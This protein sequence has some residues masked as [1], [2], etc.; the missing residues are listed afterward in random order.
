MVAD[1]APDRQ[2]EKH[3]YDAA[4]N[5]TIDTTRRGLAIGMTYDAPQPPLRTRT[6]P[7][8]AY[9]KRDDG[10][11]TLGNF[12]PHPENRNYPR[13]PL[14]PVGDTTIA[15]DIE[16]FAY[17]VMGNLTIDWARR[18][19]EPLWVCGGGRSRQLLRSIW[20]DGVPAGLRI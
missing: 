3:V 18:R 6:L 19:H 5:V 14:S 4:G 10:I 13:H 11:R 16:T 12:R 1:T 9:Q 8:V 20:V 2:V 7:A 17:D 15:G